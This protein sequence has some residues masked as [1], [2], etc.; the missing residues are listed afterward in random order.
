VKI[1][2]VILGKDEYEF[3]RVLGRVLELSEER[4]HLVSVLLD[5]D[6]PSWFLKVLHGYENVWGD[7]LQVLRHR[8]NRN[9]AG[10]R[11]YGISKVRDGVEYAVF[12]DA[13][14]WI[15]R[16]FYPA[17]EEHCKRGMFAGWLPRI[18]I[19]WIGD[20]LKGG[21]I[22]PEAYNVGEL[23]AKL[24]LDSNFKLEEDWRDPMRVVFPDWQSRL[25]KI[26][27][28]TFWRSTAHEH[29]Y[30]N[31]EGEGENYKHEWVI[32][33]RLLIWHTKWGNVERRYFR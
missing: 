11:N 6:I 3:F 7:K 28:E 12:L 25:V 29:L 9:F 18:G 2:T 21:E 19:H 22:K 17:L 32:D 14:E 31:I 4:G 10:H 5:K 27:S 20:Y 13:D 24:S 16:E 15:G 30:S 8:L 33:E 1:E 26:G 23:F